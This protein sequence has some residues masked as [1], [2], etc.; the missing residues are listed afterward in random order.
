MPM[1]GMVPLRNITKAVPGIMS[2]TQ[3]ARMVP[4]RRMRSLPVAMNKVLPLKDM[5]RMKH[6][7]LTRR[8]PSINRIL[9]EALWEKKT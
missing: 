9:S 7:L 3:L 1:V 8:L 4:K 2:T 5:V 6:S